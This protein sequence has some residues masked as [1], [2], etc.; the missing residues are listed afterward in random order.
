MGEAIRMS[1]PRAICIPPPKQ[2]P[3]IAAI[4]GT[5]TVDQSYAAR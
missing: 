1:A 3:L 2:L 4:T 5:G